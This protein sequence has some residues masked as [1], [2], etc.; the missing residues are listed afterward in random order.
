[1][2]G[3][4]E[5]TWKDGRKVNIYNIQNIYIQIL[6]KDI[7]FN[8]QIFQYEGEYQYDKKHGYGIYTWADGRKYAG[9]WAFGK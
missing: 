1:M 8:F 9:M 6:S 4:G 5:Y 3:K 2:H 7:F